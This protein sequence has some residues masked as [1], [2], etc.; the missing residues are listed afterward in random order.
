M[1]QN[2][3]VK[4]DAHKVGEIVLGEK[5]AKEARKRALELKE[6]VEKSYLELGKF[7]KLIAKA[8]TQ[9]GIPVYR[10]WGFQTFAAYCE[11]ELGFKER[12]ANHLALIYAQTEEGPFPKKWAEQVGWSKMSLLAPL[13]AKGIITEGNVKPWMERVEKSSFADL[14]EIA[15]K[16]REKAE[17]KKAKQEGLEIPSR[18]EVPESIHVIRIP[19]YD[20]QWENWN[21]ALDKARKI[22]GSDK[23]PW[24]IDCIAMAFNS[25]GFD[26]RKEG[27]D[28]VCRRVERVFRV[29]LVA[30]DEE[31]PVFGK[32]VVD[33]L[34]VHSEE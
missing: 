11:Q 30:F 27:L 16:A 6:I 18:E 5:E 8:V 14:T 29:K 7:L 2:K 33:E 32:D 20:D 21:I 23:L 13:A 15:K 22:T 26:T 12:K 3:V 28:E 31:G 17:K 10:S 4:V 24:L 34:S 9:E 1:T 25:E 19:L